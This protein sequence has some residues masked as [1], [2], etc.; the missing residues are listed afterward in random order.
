MRR[1]AVDSV[2]VTHDP[3]IDELA[4]ATK[5]PAGTVKRQPHRALAQLREVI[6][7]SSSFCAFARF[8][9]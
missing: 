9:F 1:K 7:R 8:L 6:G 3:E 5:Q 2:L 4:V